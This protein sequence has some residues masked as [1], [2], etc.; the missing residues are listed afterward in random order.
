MAAWLK[1]PLDLK[2]YV[3]SFSALQDEIKRVDETLAASDNQLTQMELSTRRNALMSI[4][5][6]LEYAFHNDELSQDDYHRN[7]KAAFKR[8]LTGYVVGIFVAVV[9]LERCCYVVVVVVVFVVVL[10][11]FEAPPRWGKIGARSYEI[12]HSPSESHEV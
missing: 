3:A 12:R 1:D 6:D 9:L 2:L 8:D 5:E 11:Q 7:M 4:C 10:G